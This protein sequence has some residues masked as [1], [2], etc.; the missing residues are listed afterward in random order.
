MD[1]LACQEFVEV[2][3][4]YLEGALDRRSSKRFEAHVRECD[5]CD[6]YL[7]QIRAMIAASGS[8]R[9]QPLE[10]ETRTAL[11]ELFRGWEASP[12]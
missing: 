2:V 11:V 10:P 3:T 1:D 5:G 12:G 8:L 4:D 6:A 9:A 7:D